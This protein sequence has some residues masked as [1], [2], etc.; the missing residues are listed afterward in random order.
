MDPNTLMNP[1]AS[2][3][4]PIAE[5]ANNSMHWFTSNFRE[6][7]L[8]AR[9][10]VEWALDLTEQGLRKAPQTLV[11]LSLALFAWQFVSIRVA[12][13]TVCAMTTIGLIGAWNE[14]MTTLAVLTTAVLLATL[15]GL[16]LGILCS[17][18]DRLWRVVRPIL[19]FMQTI[20]SF[21]YLVPVILLF[22]IGNV[23]GVIVTAFYSTPPLV[24]LTNLGL[25][26][27]DPKFIEAADA[28]GVL[29]L[30][31]LLS[32]DLPLARP[33]IMA[34]INQTVMLSLAMSVVAS[35]I[36]VAGLGRV[37]L[38]GISQLEL[39]RAMVGGVSIALIAVTVDRITQG[40]GYTRRERGNKDL[41]QQ[42]PVGWLRGMQS[43]NS[44]NI[45]K[46]DYNA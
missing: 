23:P 6:V 30:R 18:S 39:G 44:G 15:A 17:R 46:E 22:G 5:L 35:M 12:A 4:L 45:K 16:P 13:I 24:R 32:I 2:V 43:R 26:E 25:R 11:I 37:V 21:T 41:W 27:V 38:V 8:A 1:F 33:T 10:P 20:P 40:F 36:S 9:Q 31:R 19:D 7:F 29:P 34:G 42:G 3:Q 28:F 14:A